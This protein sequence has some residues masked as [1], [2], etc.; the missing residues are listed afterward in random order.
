[1]HSKDNLYSVSDDRH[2]NIDVNKLSAESYITQRVGDV[3]A[4]TT[5]NAR[6]IPTGTGAINVLMIGD[7][8]IYNQAPD[9]VKADIESHGYTANMVGTLF[10]PV[11][12][13]IEKHEGHSG[14]S[15]AYF[16][17][18]NISRT[19]PVPI[20]SE[21]AYIDGTLPQG[22][23]FYNPFVVASSATNSRNGYIFDASSY[24][25]RFNI[26][27][28]DV[29]VI[30]LGTNDLRDSELSALQADYYDEM[31]I[32][33]NSIKAA[34]SGV[35]VLIGTPSTADVQVRTDLWG[36]SV[37]INRY[38]QQLA[39]EMVDV[40]YIPLNAISS[41]DAGYLLSGAGQGFTNTVTSSLSDTIHPANSS[42]YELW[43]QTAPYI[44]AAKQNLL[45]Y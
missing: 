10:A 19:Y 6:A 11:S 7:S 16:T 24:K 12:P 21:Q 40:Y 32:I 44:V 31:K 15:A 34:W 42:R 18:K 36:K 38:A 8:I 3:F 2:L 20:G 37:A 23:N 30:G 22:K 29:V 33:I 13:S 5:V 45:E 9:Y 25:T 4:Q 43:Q 17:H 14:W 35:K 27:D 26:P 28:V 41:P 1:M 39:N